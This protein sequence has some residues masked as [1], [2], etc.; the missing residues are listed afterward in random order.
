L[1][2]IKSGPRCS[3]GF[4]SCFPPLRVTCTHYRAA[5]LLSASPLLA[6]SIRAAKGFRVVP[7]GDF[8]RLF[9][10][11]HFRVFRSL[12][13]PLPTPQMARS[14]IGLFWPSSQVPPRRCCSSGPA[15]GAAPQ[16]QPVMPPHLGR[17][18]DG[19]GSLG[20]AATLRFACPFIDRTYS[21]PTARN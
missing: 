1:A 21:R 12:L 6:E 17:V 11:R 13:L 19:R 20:H 10:E 15:L 3:A 14:K 5:A 7:I 16:M 18:E 2:S 9:W 4:R 8:P